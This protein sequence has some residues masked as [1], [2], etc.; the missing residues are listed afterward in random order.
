LYGACWT[1]VFYFKPI[2]ALLLAWPGAKGLLRLF[3]YRG[4]PS[5]VTYPDTWIRDLPLLKIGPGAY[6]SNRATLGTNMVM[7]DGTLLVDEITIGANA[8]IGHLA[9]IGP[10]ALVGDG[11]QVGVGVGVGIRCRIG[12]RVQVGPRA[13]LDHYVEV[14]EGARIGTRA[15]VGPRAKIAPGVVV[16]VNAFVP[17]GKRVQTQ[18][19]ADQLKRVGGPEATVGLT[20]TGSTNTAR[21]Q[22]GLP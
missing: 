12:A 3:G 22:P 19:E 15:Y 4:S 5:V 10:G 11:A 7:T 17:P 13:F 6:L 9:T 1:S 16:P 20:S 8:L 18:A 2:D 21:T 14:G